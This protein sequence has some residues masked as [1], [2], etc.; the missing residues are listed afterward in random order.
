MNEEQTKMDVAFPAA[1][2]KP[3]KD[4]YILTDL[5]SFLWESYRGAYGNVRDYLSVVIGKREEA[6][7]QCKLRR[8][9]PVSRTNY[10]IAFDN[11]CETLWHQMSFYPATWLVLPYLARLM[12]G[13]E[14]EQ[15]LEWLFQ[16]ILA[17][18]GWLST[19]VFGDKPDEEDVYRSYENAAVQI[20]VMTI[21]FLTHHT[22]Y[23]LDKKGRTREFAAAVTAILG[24]KKL[25]YTLFLSQFDSCYIVC[26][27]C[28]NCDEEI[29]FGY[30]DPAER[31]EAADIPTEIWDEKNQ[32]NAKLWLFH[33]FAL[34]EDREG[35]EYLRYCFGTYICP[36]CGRR[37]PVLSGM[38][39]YYI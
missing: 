17:A 39:A 35:E 37:V 5:D 21:D 10:E 27:E 22:D 36:E 19:D 14:K 23:I 20:R 34:S 38:E 12:E 13:W 30:F 16:G 6:P 26:P 1:E 33:I 15:D 3:E 24:E 7:E 25:A 2:R 9:D 28:G 32:G 8:L 29:E 4:P 18:G 11:L 31:I